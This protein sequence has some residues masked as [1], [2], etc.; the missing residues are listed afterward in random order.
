MFWAQ[1]VEDH[2][3]EW[4]PPIDPSRLGVCI[5]ALAEAAAVPCT[6]HEGDVA[7]MDAKVFHFGGAN[8][9]ELPRDLYQF[10]FLGPGP[11]SMPSDR[12]S[13]PPEYTYHLDRS[14]EGW[15]LG[16]FGTF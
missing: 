14:A 1:L 3:A 4:D 15:R 12:A 11:R 2:D 5:G 9:S 13:R 8:Q 7:I 6:L 10:S 16:D